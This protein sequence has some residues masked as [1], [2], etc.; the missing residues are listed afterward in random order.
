M[1]ERLENLQ[2]T[3]PELRM[4]QYELASQITELIHGKEATTSAL[5]ASTIVFGGSVEKISEDSFNYIL[6]EVPTKEIEK[7]KLD[8]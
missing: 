6:D 4:A 5:L 3:K 1:S 7:V 2:K 8:K